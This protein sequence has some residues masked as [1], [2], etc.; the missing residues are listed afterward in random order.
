MKIGAQINLAF[1]DD[2]SRPRLV[3]VCCVCVCVCVSLCVCVCL[4]IY[5]LFASGNIVQSGK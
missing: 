5:S 2:L 4:G 3:V 1:A